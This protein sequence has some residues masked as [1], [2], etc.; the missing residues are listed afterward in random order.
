MSKNYL[1]SYG[2]C[3]RMD[4]I[5]CQNNRLLYHSCAV[6]KHFRPAANGFF[7]SQEK[8]VGFKYN[9]KL[10]I[11]RVML[12]LLAPYW[13]QEMRTHLISLQ[14][15]WNWKLLLLLDFFSGHHSSNN[16]SV[17]CVSDWE[18]TL[19]LI[20]AQFR[21]S[22]A[23][24][25]FFLQRVARRRRRRGPDSRDQRVYSTAAEKKTNWRSNCWTKKGKRP[26]TKWKDGERVSSN[27]GG[28]AHWCEREMANYYSH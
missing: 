14:S 28:G 4:K 27:G 24:K 13:T 15:D 16:N 1:E 9:E 8:S 3:T 6:M 12:L 23:S 7:K 20:Q 21:F 19:C 11:W 25:S 2:V 10:S 18:A 26:T 17:C 5:V 22:I